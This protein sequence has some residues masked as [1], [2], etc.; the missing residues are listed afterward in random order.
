[1][2]PRP[3]AI[4]LARP[5]PGKF[6]LLTTFDLVSTIVPYVVNHFPIGCDAHE[7]KCAAHPDTCTA[8][9]SKMVNLRSGAAT[10]LKGFS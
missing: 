3:D 8:D 2:S 10:V 7:V 9:E 5:C 1:M 4:V 6:E